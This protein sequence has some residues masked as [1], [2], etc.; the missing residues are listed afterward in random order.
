MKSFIKIFL[1]IILFLP[2]KASA[3]T[4]NVVVLPVDLMN[5]CSNYYCYDEVSNII[6]EDVITYFNS[7]T[8]VAAPTLYTVRQRMSA[9]PQIR[10]TLARVLKRYRYN[11]NNIDF[12]V[13]KNIANS[14]S[15][16]SV[17][18]LSSSVKTNKSNVKRGLWEMLE[19]SSAF[20]VVYPYEM[21]TDA[22]LIDTVNDLVM[23]SGHYS[24]KVGNNNNEFWAKSPSSALAK[25]EQIKYYSKSIAA[26]SIAQDVILRFFPKT[27]NPVVT[28]NTHG[29]SAG[30]F[31]RMNNQT[32]A[33]K[34]QPQRKEDEEGSSGEIIYGL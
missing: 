28:P 21:I 10:E 17:L 7:S 3:I 2:L 34:S 6:A 11:E 27:A 15:A 12:P 23:W 19:L 5:V 22:V 8:G 14:F 29:G 33:L 24:R 25:Y 26:K 9:N 13:L 1:M 30:A 31:F 4:F 20:E 18:L 32:P 16:K